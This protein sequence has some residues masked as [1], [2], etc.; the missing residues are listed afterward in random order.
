M[1]TYTIAADDGR[2]LYRVEA[3]DQGAARAAVGQI[4]WG[5]TQDEIEECCGVEFTGAWHTFE[6]KPAGT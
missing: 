6:G 4:A 2:M 3:P 5:N 1:S